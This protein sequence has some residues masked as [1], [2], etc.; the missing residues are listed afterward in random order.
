MI[1]KMMPSV[2]DEV[3]LS[4]R[5]E[6]AH[7]LL[8]S[9]IPRDELLRNLGLY[10]L[11]M[12][13]R[14]FLFFDSLYRLFL[15]TPGIICEFGCRWGQNLALLQSLR[16]IYEPFNRHRRIVGFD[17]FSGLS[18]VTIKDGTASIVS[19]GAY[20]VSDKYA[21]YLNNILKL[22]ET[23]SPLPQIVKFEVVNGDASQT[24]EKF[25]KEH[26]EAIIAFA[27]FDMDIYAPT[28]RCL[29]L[30]RPRLTKGS[31][32][33]FDELNYPDFPGETVAFQEIFGANNVRLQRNLWSG[34]ETFF[35]VD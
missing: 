4:A 3:T 15:N 23:Q 25:L 21:D 34:E 5:R 7:G 14:R 24:F 11:P 2:M 28:A 32:V 8:K 33:G 17:T 9:P 12:D 1:Q 22:K 29:E 30:L 13:L 26:P 10:L 20:S 6:I 31:V 35:V 19:D 16:A 18:G 27:Y